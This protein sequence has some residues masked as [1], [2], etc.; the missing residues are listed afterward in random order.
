MI[1]RIKSF[2]P[3][4]ND[5]IY[6][7]LVLFFSWLII[8]N[9]NLIQGDQNVI[10]YHFSLS[11]Y[12]VFTDGIVSISIPGIYNSIIHPSSN[13][14]AIH[15][16]ILTMI[17]YTASAYL[18]AKLILT[19]RRMIL[20]FMLFLF[21]SRFPM[22]WLSRELY[23]GV[24]LFLS[25]T[26][27]VKRWNPFL[28][29]V[30]IVLCGQTK[31]EM[32]VVSLMFM[33][34]YLVQLWSQKKL[35]WKLII[36]YIVLNFIIISPQIF[37]ITRA[38]ENDRA[39]FSFGQHYAALFHQHQ[40]SP[41][42]DPFAQSVAYV[43]A[44]FPGAENM[45]DIISKYPSAYLDYVA[46]SIFHGIKRSI[47]L[48]HFLLFSLFL[49]PYHWIKQNDYP[50]QLMKLVIISLI[51]LGPMVLFSFPHIRY[52]ARYYPLIILAVLSFVEKLNKQGKN[53][54]VF[55]NIIYLSLT[56]NL[57]IYFTTLDGLSSG[58]YWFP[59]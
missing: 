30:L 43:R 20:L 58:N 59:D 27:M 28:T 19:K 48:F 57:Y 46:L 54:E 37:G 15:I 49:I 52:L 51:G 31:P 47:V 24:F 3:D 35:C 8:A 5:I 11:S 10:N 33:S 42:S 34:Y 16:R 44:V 39:F 40:V 13:Q 25:V 22:L 26:A 7:G 2:R 23:I 55:N 6:I 36:M 32:F 18:M 14:I 29:T 38:G 1:N 9:P 17:L 45:K 56:V 50:D 12:P 53:I 4:F 41:L 21:S